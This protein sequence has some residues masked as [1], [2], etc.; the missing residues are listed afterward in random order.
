MYM[1]IGK[2]VVLVLVEG[3]PRLLGGLENQ[4][5]GYSS[6]TTTTTIFVAW[7]NG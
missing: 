4:V 6:T 3:R 5:K 1:Y 2:P 7:T